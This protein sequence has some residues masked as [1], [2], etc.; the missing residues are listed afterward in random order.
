MTEKTYHLIGWTLFIVCA[1]LYTISGL[2]SGDTLTIV[3]SIV[4]LVA[5]FAFIVPLIQSDN[6]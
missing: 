3:G 4:F 2:R 6:A 5:C 1:V